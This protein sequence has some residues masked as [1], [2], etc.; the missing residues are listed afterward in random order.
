[1]KRMSYKVRPSQLC[2]SKVISTGVEPGNPWNSQHQTNTKHALNFDP[3]SQW[4]FI[5]L[6]NLSMLSFLNKAA[7]SNAQRLYLKVY[8]VPSK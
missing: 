3:F 6:I 8:Y 5:S 7:F 2:I 4:T 1:M